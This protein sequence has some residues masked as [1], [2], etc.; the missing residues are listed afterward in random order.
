VTRP[1]RLLVIG[2]LVSDIRIV[3]QQPVALGEEVEGLISMSGGGSAANQAGWLAHLG[4]DVTFVGRIGADVVGAALIEELERSGVKVAAVTD[5]LYPSGTVACLISDSG[6]RSL[7]TSRGANRRLEASDVS[8]E[9]W[10]VEMLVL[11]GYSFSSAESTP[12]ARAFMAEARRR[13][14]P[15]ALDPASARLFMAYPGAARFRAWTAGARW[16][17]PSSTEAR[18]LAGCASDS[19]AASELLRSY[20]GVVVT[21][22][23]GGCLV[24]SSEG[25]EPLAVPPSRPAGVVDTTGAGDA[26]VAG[27]LHAWL[28]GARPEEAARRGNE[29]AAQALSVEGG[30]PPSAIR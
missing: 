2:D 4:A 25:P 18:A 10:S 17:F 22:G 3:P 6:E 9:C 7:I 12:A 30:R 23:A 28:G 19:T 16:L 24:A 26:F 13:E 21:Q 15:V 1:P 29:V 8:E 27:F 11:T 5:P 14:L 20:G